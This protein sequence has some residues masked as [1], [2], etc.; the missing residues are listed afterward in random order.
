MKRASYIFAATAIVVVA[1]AAAYIFYNQG[2]RPVSFQV[3][4]NTYR[5]TSYAYTEAERATGL[6]NATVTNDT[7]MLFRFDNPGIYPFWMKDTYSPLD[8]IWLNYSSTDGT[9]KVV[10]IANATPCIEY[11]SSQDSCIV[12]TPRS[13]ANY[14]LEARAGFAKANDMTAGT[15][16]RFLYK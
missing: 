12:Y 4:G 6:M 2:Q 16:I 15:E 5:I 14:V 1:A 13:E 9:A 8:I 10:Y 11:S 7:F 3:N